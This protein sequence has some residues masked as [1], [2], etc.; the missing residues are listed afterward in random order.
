[1][2]RS[3]LLRPR[4]SEGLEAAFEYYQRILLRHTQWLRPGQVEQCSVEEFEY[5]INRVRRAALAMR[6]TSL[7][8]GT[9]A[10]PHPIQRP[11]QWLVPVQEIPDPPASW[12]VIPTSTEELPERWDGLS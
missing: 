9:T 10:Y 5:N 7:L 12:T 6:L 4:T 1:M 2:R 11:S 8:A 3:P